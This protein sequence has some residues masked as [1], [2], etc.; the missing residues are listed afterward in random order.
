[1]TYQELI[2]RALEMDAAREEK[3]VMLSN[4]RICAFLLD[5]CQLKLTD[6]NYFF[7][8]TNLKTFEGRALR[9]VLDARTDVLPKYRT[10]A[11]TEAIE[12]KAYYG[13]QDLSHTAPDW[14]TIFRLGLE[15]L[16]QRVLART[17]RPKNP[18]F[19][20]ATVTVLEAAQ[21]FARRCA[22]FARENGREQ[23]AAGLENL[24]EKGPGDLYEA[25][26][27]TLFYYNLQQYFEAIDV[28]TMGRLD[29]LTAPFATDP[30]TA[31]ALADRY[32]LEIDAIGAYAN[33]PFAL[34]GSDE[35]G[36][37]TVNFMSYIL[38]DAYKKRMLP[39]VKLHILCTPDIPEDFLLC[40][41]DSIKRGGNSLVFINDPV[42]VQG[43][44]KLGIEREDARRYSIVGCYEASA[45]EEIPCS[46]STRVNLVKAL[47]YTLHAGKD[48]RTGY[49]VGLAKAPDYAT[50]EALYETFW[51]NTK[52][53]CDSAMLLTN[54]AEARNPVRYAAP[55]F[56]AT[57]EECVLR[58]GDAYADHC[59]R[60]NNSSLMA[61]GL[62]T[63]VDSLYAI[64]HLVYDTGLVTLSQLTEILKNNWEGQEALR[65]F[66]R[67]KLP[68]YGNG[69][70][71]VDD[72]AVDLAHRLARL[73][74]GAPNGRGGVYRLG[75]FSIDWRATWGKFTAAT[76]D[77]RRNG[78]SLSQNASAA[79][80]MDREGPTGHILS[81]TRLPGEDAV[82]GLVLDMEMHSS[83]VRGENGTKV[84]LATLKTFLEK[85]GQTVH[86]NILDTETLKD[87]QLH[88]ENHQNLQVRVCGWN[89]EF[90]KMK[91]EEQDEYIL[92]SQ[93]QMR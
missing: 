5:H 81:V 45:R 26:Q 91:K 44:E 11:N 54:T 7:M 23:M 13:S 10:Q 64:K 39:N 80:G 1:M 60:Y 19:V 3:N 63:V 71:R 47:E 53:L 17:G 55:L 90:I 85:G 67:N 70:P 84:L 76:P 86:Y 73:V 12:S 52:Y 62:G 69:D 20:E 41:M 89:A 21:R 15:G 37:T 57:L 38:L 4:A 28:R 78:D 30:E 72:L 65:N 49:T 51:A 88:P 50:F 9:V 61:V 14:E 22:A 66:I 29:Q 25:F 93:L 2:S 18:H 87:A 56:S 77:G 40:C 34:G 32:L 36:K 68:K 75:I 35:K 16:K 27:M 33:M 48:L 79:F 8:E 92:R 74:N 59:A 24:A 46:C 31:L 83:A 58:G 82:N 42:M 6:K 43:L